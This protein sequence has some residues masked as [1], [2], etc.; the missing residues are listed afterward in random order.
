MHL[1]FQY[2]SFDESEL[3]EHK[4]RGVL[5]GLDISSCSLMAL[6]D[7]V[8]GVA[9]SLEVLDVKWN[10][11]QCLPDWLGEEFSCL[12]VL[13]CSFNR[14]EFLPATIG[15]LTRLEDMRLSDNNLKIV[16][17]SLGHMSSLLS[18]QLQ[19]N[20]LVEVPPSFRLLRSIN[21]AGN[22]LRKEGEEGPHI[23]Y[24]ASP[25]QLARSA[26]TSNQ[27]GYLRCHDTSHEI[28]VRTNSGLPG[29]CRQHPHAL[30]V[31]N[32]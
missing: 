28:C 21:L 31:R 14:L 3:D 1:S 2:R 32:H 30:G 29:A 22:P 5:R 18:L 23:T 26:L 20:R 15:L 17:Q 11:I 6:P 7:S 13:D 24:P 12:K 16:P 4:R 10:Q 9:S 19:Y 27:I 8:R 25:P